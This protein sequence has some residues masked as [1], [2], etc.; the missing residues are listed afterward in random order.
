MFEFPTP[1]TV[2]TEAFMPGAKDEFNNPVDAWE[3][4]VQ[5][6]VIGWEPPQSDEPKLAGH[7]RVVVEL[8]LYAP[9]DFIAGP[10]DRVTINGRTYLVIGYPEGT[11]GN[12]FEWAPGKTVN[13]RRVEG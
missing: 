2:D 7:D 3:N 13:L 9:P 6:P 12:P 1:Y 11:D 10:N 4:P 8:E 5:Q